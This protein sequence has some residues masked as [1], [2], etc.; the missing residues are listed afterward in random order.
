M[1]DAADGLLAWALASFHAATLV[2][3][4]V[5]TLYAVGALGSLLQGV[6]TEVGL[7]LYLSLWGITWATNR[8]WL[9]DADLRGVRGTCVP[10]ATWGAVA[11]LAFLAVLLAVVGL[12]VGEVVLVAAL[13]LVGTPVAA[14]V[15]ALVGG[16]FALV[17]LALLGVGRRLGGVTRS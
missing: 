5:G 4:G 12:T 11:G 14:L 16:G 17:D 2:T 7:G 6:R 3:A 1:A 15:G 9:T 13:A 10:G 8:R